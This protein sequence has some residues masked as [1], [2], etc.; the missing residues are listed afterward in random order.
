M[1]KENGNKNTTTL[2]NPKKKKNGLKN[3]NQ[4]A[5]FNRILSI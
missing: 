5:N 2:Q 4:A 3:K 1:T